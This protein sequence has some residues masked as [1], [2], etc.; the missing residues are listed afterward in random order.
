MRCLFCKYPSDTTH[1]IEHIIPQSLGNIDHTLPKGWVCDKCNQ[2]FSTKVEKLLLDTEYFRHARFRNEV[3]SK[4][5]RIPSIPAYL[6]PKKIEMEYFIDK[7]GKKGIAPK[8]EKSE[9]LLIKHLLSNQSGKFIIP[10]PLSPD[11]KLVSRFL[12]KIAL[13]ALAFKL[14]NTDGSLDYLVDDP[15]LDS[16][17]R[18]ARYAEG[19]KYWPFSARRI[20][21]EDKLFTDERGANFE[22]LH[23]FDLLYTNENELYLV[24]AIFGIEYVI[25]CAGPELD[26]YYKWLEENNNLS[27]LYPVNIIQK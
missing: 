10:E 9:R 12:A 25:N 3:P 27:P 14:K 19:N 18:Y 17:R 2:Y 13:E 7:V 11:E 20:Y 1:G 8:N 24:C 5:G 6:F 4:K 22:I 16:L 23:E 21:A 26:G 15:Q